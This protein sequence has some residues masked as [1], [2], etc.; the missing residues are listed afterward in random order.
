MIYDKSSPINS[1][2]Y[3]NLYPENGDRVV[4]NDFVTSFH[5]K[6]IKRLYVFYSD[7][8]S[9]VLSFKINF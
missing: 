7:Y 5:P 6:Y 1:A 9:H 2:H 3:V 8:S 4:A